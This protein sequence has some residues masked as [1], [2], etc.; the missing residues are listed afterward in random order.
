MFSEYPLGSIR[1]RALLLSLFGIVLRLQQIERVGHVL[2]QQASHRAARYA[3][4][5][6]RLSIGVLRDA[7]VNSILVCTC[8]E[9]E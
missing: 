3:V 7:T 5:N 8:K 9:I 1:I 4:Q 2:S 6:D